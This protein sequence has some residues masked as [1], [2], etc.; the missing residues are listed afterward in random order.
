MS[1]SHKFDD[2]FNECIERLIKGDSIQS[3][4]EAFPEYAITT[5]HAADIQPRLEFRQQAAQEFQK[6]VQ[7]LTPRHTVKRVWKWQLRWVI[8][9][10]AVFAVLVAGTGTVFA[11]S[12]SLPDQTLYPVK[13]FTENARVTLTTSSAGKAQLYAQFADTRVNEIV[14]MADEGK[15]AQIEKTTERMNGYFTAIAR[16]TQSDAS[17]EKSGQGPVLFGTNATATAPQTVTIHPTITPPSTRTTPNFSSWNTTTPWPST[18]KS[19][20][21]SHNTTAVP[22]TG[23]KTV[24]ANATSFS[25][26]RPTI[27]QADKTQL[28]SLISQQAEKNAEKLKE[29]LNRVPDSA[30]P[31]LEKA[32]N[33]AGKGYGQ[34]LDNI[35]NKK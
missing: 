33:D 27:N 25:S 1:N 19:P 9:V 2:I 24:S 31:S 11:A 13:I 17:I 23:L 22:P 7:N 32:I 21:T 26:K 30:K 5:L 20:V 8:P 3:C 28:Q 14:K 29:A 35:G 12:D 16:L 4:L 18:V 6:A 34:A 15:I 10:T